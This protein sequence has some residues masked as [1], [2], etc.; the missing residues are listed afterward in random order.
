MAVS[1]R[2][3]V[4]RRWIVAAR[5]A[6]PEFTGARAPRDAPPGVRLTDAEGA[7][8]LAERFPKHLARGDVAEHR[9]AVRHVLD[10]VEALRA[11][12]GCVGPAV[13]RQA[14]RVL[15]WSYRQVGAMYDRFVREGGVPT[16]ALIALTLNMYA[17]EG[18]VVR[19]H[20]VFVHL[21]RFHV[22]FDER[23]ASAVVHVFAQ[24]GDFA[25]AAS[26]YFTH[27][28]RAWP[29]S[30]L[31]ISG[32]LAAR[33]GA[34]LEVLRAAPTF[35]AGEALMNAAPKE[36]CT[37]R[38]VAAVARRATSHAQVAAF[39]HAH[40]AILAPPPPPAPAVIDPAAVLHTEDG[41]MGW[42][43]V[44]APAEGA[45]PSEAAVR[46]MA[47]SVDGVADAGA[48][49]SSTMPV[50]LGEQLERKAWFEQAD[51]C[52]YEAA[53]AKGGRVEVTASSARLFGFHALP[54]EVVGA[55]LEVAAA[56]ESF[57]T[58]ETA[59]AAAVEAAEG[60]TSVWFAN[61][62]G[63]VYCQA[64]AREI[65]RSPRRIPARDPLVRACEALVHRA[66]LDG[67]VGN[68]LLAA[69][70]GVY[71]AGR[72]CDSARRYLAWLWDSAY[73]VPLQVADAARPLIAA[74]REEQARHRNSTAGQAEAGGAGAGRHDR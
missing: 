51:A 64:V 40:A 33:G 22:E 37:A 74:A 72:L 68:D 65:R 47:D 71:A 45:A 29:Q 13:I 55:V 4:Q 5:Y 12:G 6:P 36:L 31:G 7:R 43:P 11:R 2:R 73:L 23:H 15:P 21:R 57:L 3:V 53:E 16:A 38:H 34:L 44:D 28:A 56:H 26:L 30:K 1:M 69:L 70:M 42:M 50:L 52:G 67:T 17:R 32:A 14:A 20:D 46:D 66:V 63:R 19:V 25:T 24:R 60:S 61:V 62:V 9:H 41:A 58:F 54:A 39:L 49:D 27:L 48:D 18:N 8:W 10:A 59:A 35:A